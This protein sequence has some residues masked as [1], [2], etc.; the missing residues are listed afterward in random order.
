MVRV[1]QLLGTCGVRRIIA[2]GILGFALCVLLSASAVS[3]E[4]QII[5][6]D[7]LVADIRQFVS[8]LETAHPDPYINGGGKIAFHQRMQ[9]ALLSIPEQGMTAA[10]FLDLLRPLMASLGDSH[11]MLRTPPTAEGQSS[12]GLPLE[13][14]I[15]EQSLYVAGVYGHAHEHLLGARLVAIEGVPL[16]ELLLRQ[17]R[18]RGLETLYTRLA[19]LSR[20]LRNGRNL[21]RL[22]P[23]CQDSTRIRISLESPSG[24]VEQYTLP[25]VTAAPD[26]LVRP[27]TAI[28]T[29]STAH[30]DVVYNFLDSSHVTA[31][32]VI[33]DMMRYREG[34][35]GWYAAGMSEAQAF[36][37]E[38][39]RHFHGDSQIPQDKDSLLAAIPAAT[40]AF[41]DLSK[42]MKRAGTKT[43]IVDLR[44]NTGGNSV[45]LNFLVYFLYGDSTM[46]ALEN[47]YSVKKLSSLY[48]DVF[49]NESLA[50]INEGRA[51]PLAADDY[52]FD[53]KLLNPGERA[54]AT[55]DS[56]ALSRS[57]EE[58][59]TFWEVYQQGTYSGYY[60]PEKIIVLCSPFTFSSGFNLMTALYKLGALVVGTP[61]AQAGNNFGD[62][63]PFTLKHSG[64]NGFVSHKRVITF[65]DDAEK[66]NCLM[67]DVL[68]T[69]EKLASYGFDPNAELRLAMEV[70]RNAK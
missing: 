8:I 51:I 49:S 55:A 40:E 60:R 34:C 23:E 27:E 19:I 1:R 56:E 21:R 32:L 50:K 29:P 24:R 31:L 17:S 39:Y 30:S 63:M 18:D 9:N 58:M 48:F 22:V 11:T 70:L 28:I 54:T 64:I 45:M 36:T 25:L 16:P 42:D 66:G 14:K 61:S 35:E 3:A 7:S 37:Q 65:P 46:K 6:R 59:P 47:W 67:P 62:S 20:S 43:L 68:L 12:P 13:L 15:I 57:L 33:S 44:E 2:L 4:G 26:S 53:D 41:V 10:D 38:A 5:P 52:V 69:Y